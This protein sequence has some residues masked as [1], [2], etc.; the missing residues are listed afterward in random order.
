[1]PNLEIQNRLRIDRLFTGV[2]LR[3]SIPSMPAHTYRSVSEWFGSQ[4]SATPDALAIVDQEKRLTYAQLDSQSNEVAK[5]LRA[6]GMD[7]ECVVGLCTTRSA[8]FVVGALGILKSGAA[9]LPID[10]DLPA[11][12]QSYLLNDCS[13]PI[14]VTEEKFAGRIARSERTVIVLNLEGQHQKDLPRSALDATADPERLAYVIYTSGSTGIPKGVEITQANLMNLIAWHQE[15]FEITPS[16]RATQLAGLGFDA[17]V[18]EIWP[19]LTAGASVH[20]IPDDIRTDP[21]RLRDWL[22]HHEITIGYVPTALAEVLLGLDWPSKVSLRTMLTGADALHRYPTTHL[23]FQLVN[24]YGPTECTVVATSGVVPATENCVLPPSIG[25]PIK[26]AIA[27]LL[28][29]NCQQLA[30]GEQGELYIGGLGVARGYRNRPEL[31]AEQFIS[32]PFTDGTG[33]RLYRTGDLAYALADG[34][35]IFVGRKDDQLKIDGYRI[36]PNEIVQ[37]LERHPSVQSACIL[38]MEDMSGSKR[39]VA[40]V[41]RKTGFQL[42][43]T[44]LRQF[45]QRTQPS[46]MI[47]A[48]FVQMDALPL[49]S[50]G[51]VD[52]TALPSPEVSNILRDKPFL[53]PRTLLEKVVAEIVQKLVDLDQVGIE[54]NFFALGGHSLMAA[55]LIAKLRARFGVDLPLQ[56]VFEAPTIAQLSLELQKLIISKLELMSEEEAQRLEPD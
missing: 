1:M 26:N 53:A 3:K 46:Y 28:D 52:R 54:D 7:S 4:A 21:T 22:V 41:V 12:R 32:N 47:P 56:A 6:V 17:A 16:D 31:T 18:W 30:N 8:S 24:N 40:Y 27:Y 29:E 14:L 19:Y 51:K 20:F 23:P 35:L 45:L 5:S 13:A 2:M 36:E 49:T 11:A 50:N 10:P 55:E 34:Q 43:E 25:R 15:A 39:L 42:R 44:E 37:N 33:S 38:A 48:I 9:Y